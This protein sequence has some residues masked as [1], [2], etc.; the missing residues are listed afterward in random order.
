M[1]L[2]VT[3]FNYV[4]LTQ[5]HVLTRLNAYPVYWKHV[6]QSVSVIR[7]H[8]GTTGA[9]LLKIVIVNMHYMRILLADMYVY[10]PGG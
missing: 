2:L 4:V 6:S 10:S 9:S 5:P 1:P 3:I 7:L 8:G